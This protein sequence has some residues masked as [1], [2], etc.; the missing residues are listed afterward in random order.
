MIIR[1]TLLTSIAFCLLTGMDNARAHSWLA[2]CKIAFDNNF[3]LT[4]NYAQARSTFASHT[5]LSESGE[6]EVCD[7]DTHIACWT[8]RERCGS[9]G[10][11][12]VEEVPIGRHGHFHL[13]FEDTSL[14]CFVGVGDGLEAGFGRPTQNG[15]CTAADWENEPRFASGHDNKH[16]MRIWVEDR[17][18]HEPRIFDVGSIRIRGSADAEVWFRKTD[19][20]WWYWPRLTPGRWNLSAWTWEISDVYVRAAE[21]EGTSVSFDD[22][23]V[24]N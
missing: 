23:V 11:V 16:F 4:W 18:N 21:G 12:N 6:A 15:G 20:T 9:R 8:Y 22:V 14:T 2:E 7:T 3:A 13:S 19:G 1:I 24:R 10:Y 17:V 5:G